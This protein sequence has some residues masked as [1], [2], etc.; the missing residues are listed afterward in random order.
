MP[1]ITDDPYGK[2][3]DSLMPF[4]RTAIPE[5]L[6]RTG[7]FPIPASLSQVVTS[8]APA[9]KARWLYPRPAPPRLRA[10]GADRADAAVGPG[11]ADRGRGDR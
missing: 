4:A 6:H 1:R 5:R 7:A 11:R 3:A 2:I 8:I 9:G 10:A